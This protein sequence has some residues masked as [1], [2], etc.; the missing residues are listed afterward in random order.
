MFPLAGSIGWLVAARFVDRVGKGIRGAPR[1]ALVADLSPPALR[2]ASFG[3]RQS[4]DTVG[5]FTGPLLAILFLWLSGSRFRLVLW[6]AVPPA[7]LA[8][9]LIVV[10]VPESRRPADAPPPRMPLRRR[11]AARLGGGYWAIVA[12]AT[13]FTLARFSEAFLILRAQGLGVSMVLVPAVLVVMNIAYAASAFPVGIL[14]DRVERMAV[15]ATGLLLLVAADLVLALASGW[16]ALGLGAAL[17]GLHMGFSQG[18]FATLIA[19][20]APADSRGTA[21]GVYNL[22]TGLAL[23]AA[24]M[25]A[26]ALWDALGAAATFLAGALFAAL[27]LAALVALRGHLPRRAVSAEPGAP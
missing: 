26:G 22:V 4:L 11:D 23:L 14:V 3:L 15:L 8:L 21:F 13:L 25:I 6:L 12:V 10:A 20:V 9:A 1:D 19:D 16:V 27:T 5:A 24:S 7:F 2:G 17:W 18:L